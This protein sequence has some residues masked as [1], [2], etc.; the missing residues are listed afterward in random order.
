MDSVGMS[1]LNALITSGKGVEKLLTMDLKKE[2]FVGDEQELYEYL[3]NHVQKFGVIPASETL[4]KELE[5]TVTP[6]AEP[7]EYYLEHVE[8]RYM[9]SV[10]KKGI[11][12]AVDKLK[13]KEPEKALAILVD[14]V[15]HLIL[16]KH[17]KELVNF[18]AE[19]KKLIKNEYTKKLL[20]GDQYGIPMGWPTLDNMIQGLQGGDVVAIVGRPA[21]GKTYKMLYSAMNA[22][23]V[24]KKV[25]MFVSMEIKNLLLAQRLAALFSKVPITKL[26]NAEL[27]T[28]MYKKVL[29]DLGQLSE[30]GLPF[31]LVDGNMTATVPEILLLARNLK[32]DVIYIDGGYLLKSTN[33]RDHGW[34]VTKNTVEGIKQ[35]LAG[36]LNIPVV[37][38]Y[39]FNKENKKSKEDA[40]MDNIAHSDAIAQI[41]SIILGMFQDDSVET[42]VEKRIDILK[43]RSG[44]TGSFKINW[45]FDNFPYM[46]FSEKKEVKLED[47][48]FL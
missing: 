18:A 42:L 26:K 1:L 23:R 20:L 39:Q 5:V 9:Q 28:Q 8:K 6:V 10:L 27:S 37:V 25:P 43:G 4:E 48:S 17:R 3:M 47:L 40:T 36:S 7:A 13:E 31:W 16:Q 12:D 2:L 38:S 11:N 21:Q 44:E 29:T 32:P 34:Q 22:H 30:E 35:Q 15:Q 24:A 33:P 46:N 45:Q 19:G 14:N 41:A